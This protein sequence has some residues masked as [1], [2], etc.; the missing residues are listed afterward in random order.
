MFL[1]EFDE[2]FRCTV[3]DFKPSVCKSYPFQIKKGKLIQMSEKM[4]PVEWNTKE[5]EAMM[6]IHLKKD[7]EEWRFYDKL[8]LEWNSKNKIKKPLSEFLKFMM[9]KVSLE[10]TKS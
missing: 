6:S 3:N 2:V 9:Q 8:I 5:F 4:C 7:E 10:I 1:E